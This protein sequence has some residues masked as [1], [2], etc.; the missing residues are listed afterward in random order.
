MRRR[1]PEGETLAREHLAN[2]RTLLSW[3]RTGIN[4]IGAGILLYAVAGALDA[5]LQGVLPEVLEHGQLTLLSVGVVIFGALVELAAVARYIQYRISI[6]RGYLTSPTP[7]YL[8]VTLSLVFIGVAYIL[9]VV[10][11]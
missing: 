5:L 11:A 6:R 9:Y 3:I 7:I 8:L 2:E 1:I 10:V 4:A